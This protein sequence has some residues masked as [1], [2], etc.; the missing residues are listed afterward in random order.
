[1]KK[2][3][4]LFVLLVAMLPTWAQKVAQKAKKA[5]GV[6]F[7]KIDAAQVPDPVKTAFA[8]ANA[9]ATPTWEKHTARGKADKSFT[10]YVAV[11]AT[12]DGMKNRA[13]YK[14]DGTVMSS[15]KYMK[16]DKMPDGIKAGMKSKYP[17]FTATVAENIKGKDAKSVYRVKSKKGSAKLTA[18]FDENGN[19]ITKDKVTDEVKEGED[20]ENDN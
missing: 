9:G 16:A 20:E 19:E 13:R 11:F 17:D 3:L 14:E 6:N 4:L 7:E 1:M 15:S 5:K 8:A 2:T 18:Y 10:K 12:A